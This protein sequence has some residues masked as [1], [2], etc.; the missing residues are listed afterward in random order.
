MATISRTTSDARDP[1]AAAAATAVVRRR[2]PQQQLRH[3][4]LPLSP[5]H[6]FSGPSALQRLWAPSSSAP[7]QPARRQ[8]RRLLAHSTPSPPSA[9]LPP[10]PLKS[11]PQAAIPPRLSLPVLLRPLLAPATSQLS[12]LL[13]LLLLV[14]SA[15]LQALCQSDANG[16]PIP[17]LRQTMVIKTTA[18]GNTIPVFYYV[19]NGTAS[20]VPATTDSSGTTTSS[21]STGTSTGTDSTTTTTDSSSGGDAGTSTSTSTTADDTSATPA[22]TDPT[23]TPPTNEAEL[24][25][26]DDSSSSS[27]TLPDRAVVCLHGILRWWQEC[28]VFAET[29]AVSR[30]VIV[31]PYFN[32]AEQNLGGNLV[33]SSNT[34]DDYAEGTP[35]FGSQ[36]ST[37]TILDHLLADVLAAYPSVTRLTVVGFSAGAQMANRYAVLSKTIESLRVPVRFV[38]GS[39]SSFLFFDGRRLPAA[40][41]ASLTLSPAPA[42]A[43][44]SGPGFSTPADFPQYDTTA[45]KGVAKYKFGLDPTSEVLAEVRAL[46]ADP[47]AVIARYVANRQVSFLAELDDT[48]TDGAILSKG[49]ASMAQGT[50]RLNRMLHYI[51]YLR[52]LYGVTPDYF[53]ANGCGHDGPC[54][55]RIDTVRENIFSLFTPRARP[56]ASVSPASPTGTQNPTSGA[57]A[58]ASSCPWPPL[59]VAAVGALA[60]VVP[61]LGPGLF[62]VAA[63]L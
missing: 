35:A 39:G 10:S 50:N 16:V 19:G 38:V 9:P 43:L 28:F 53:T 49:C 27:S 12:F 20:V 52:A 21:A 54:V 17:A 23:T 14:S 22:P 2:Q 63:V 30:S 56:S 11:Q 36:E 45:C 41:V 5:L 44:P 51:L 18:E 61:L 40:T 46:L 26:R 24:F 47:S 60:L 33:W 7:Q 15:S 31:S 1:A 57:S 58:S 29:D 48:S 34:T 6:T 42:L 62:G 25:A 37:F 32:T 55:Y 8:L 3:E 59:R 13:L 4:Q